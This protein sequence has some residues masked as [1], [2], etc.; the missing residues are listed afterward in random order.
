MGA[1]NLELLLFDFIT[2][3]L[4]GAFSTAYTDYIAKNG[5]MIQRIQQETIVTCLR[6]YP[7]KT[8]RMVGIQTEIRTRDLLN[9]KELCPSNSDVRW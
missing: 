9:M 2:W 7:T 1:T 3:L 6:Y 5:V 4:K 8:D